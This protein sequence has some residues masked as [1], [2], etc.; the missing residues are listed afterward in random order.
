MA[1]NDNNR[2]RGAYRHPHTRRGRFM[3][4]FTSFCCYCRLVVLSLV[5]LSLF[6]LFFLIARITQQHHKRNLDVNKDKGEARN[7]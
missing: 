7:S 2:S 5:V 6:P 4:L 1:G 3:R